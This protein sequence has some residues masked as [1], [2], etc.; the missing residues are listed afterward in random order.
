MSQ[1]VH[2]ISQK[3]LFTVVTYRVI[4]FRVVTNRAKEIFTHAA[5]TLNAITQ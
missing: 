3:L 4:A 2:R 5:A 1:L